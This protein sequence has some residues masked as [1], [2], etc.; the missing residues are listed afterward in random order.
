MNLKLE[1]YLQIQ[2]LVAAYTLST[3]NKDV[4]GFMNCWVAP[5]DFGGYDSGAFGNLKT[6]EEL[7]AFEAHHVGPG[8]DANG[9]RHLA[10]N[11]QIVPVSDQEVKITHDMVV[12]EVAEIP[13]VVAT[14][15]YNDSIAVKTTADSSNYWRNGRRHKLPDSCIKGNR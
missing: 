6:W 7:K 13:F 9:K 15:R 14:G 5:E 12:L 4:E 8:G 10:L 3:D 1:D 11:L 2:N